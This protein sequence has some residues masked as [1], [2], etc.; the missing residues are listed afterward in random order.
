ITFDGYYREETLDA[1]TGKTEIVTKLFNKQIV[2]FDDKP[3]KNSFI[4]ISAHV[5]EYGRFHLWKIIKGLGRDKALYCDTD[6]VK[7]RKRD[8]KF[9]RSALDQYELGALKV[10]EESKTLTLYGPKDYETESTVKL[11]GV[12]RHA[13]KLEDGKY[14]YTHFPRQDTHLRRQI[15]R[16]FITTPMEKKLKRTY[17]KGKV[18]KDGRVIPITLSEPLPPSLLRPLF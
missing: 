4:A 6:S 9:I 16:Y 11:K 15:T 8:L 2:A 13:V 7:I 17:T 3:G 10:E 14:R 12:P 18:L 1:V 5:A